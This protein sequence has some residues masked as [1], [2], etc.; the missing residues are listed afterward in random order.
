MT[1]KRVFF[2]LLNLTFYWLINSAITHKGIEE[3]PS[4]FILQQ[5]LTPPHL[6]NTCLCLSAPTDHILFSNRSQIHSSLKHHDRALR[7][8]ETACRLTPLWSKVR[9]TSPAY[10]ASFSS[11]SGWNL[12]GCLS[13]WRQ[14]HV[15]KAQ[16]LASV[17]RTEDALREYLICLSIEPDCRLAKAEAHKV[18]FAFDNSCS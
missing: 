8:A 5:S 2:I 6:C 9:S 3:Q 1:L 18:G 4:Y 16:A 11:W 12:I 15:R 10:N 13:P 14:G 17:G 7:D